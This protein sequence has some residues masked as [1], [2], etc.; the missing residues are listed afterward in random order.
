LIIVSTERDA[1]FTLDESWP[2]PPR[3]Y[4]AREEQGNGIRR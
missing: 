4:L 2:T 3:E 1:T